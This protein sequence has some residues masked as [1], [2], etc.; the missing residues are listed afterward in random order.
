MGLLGALIALPSPMA[1]TAFGHAFQDNP[2]PLTADQIS[3]VEQGRYLESLDAY[4]LRLFR[5]SGPSIS[6]DAIPTA[7]LSTLLELA[8]VGVRSDLSVEQIQD[9][10]GQ[11]VRRTASG[12]AG[13]AW[14]REF[15]VA[16]SNGVFVQQEG[17]AGRGAGA[18]RLVSCDVIY[19][20]DNRQ[21]SI[22]H[23]QS[24]V[25]LWSTSRLLTPFPVAKEG[26]EMFERASWSERDSPGGLIISGGPPGA[27]AHLEFRFGPDGEIDSA[28]SAIGGD[29]RCVNRVAISR[30]SADLSRIESIRGA[31]VSLAGAD[32]DAVAYFIQVV[33]GSSQGERLALK[34]PLDAVVFDLRSTP[35][36]YRPSRTE[37][38]P[39]EI[40]DYVLPRDIP[41]FRGDRSDLVQLSEGSEP[42]SFL[43]S[44]AIFVATLI[45][46]AVAWVAVKEGFHQRGPRA[47]V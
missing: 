42:W 29:F 26:I 33:D 7:S 40:V 25:A 11:L 38:W 16:Q 45:L 35:K 8:K 28:S 34:V 21:V 15:H 27:G 32:L 18:A 10:I 24:G 44:A 39:P 19:E 30:S 2:I 5:Y 43:K 17:V 14:S 31:Y 46:V 12:G 36:H 41:E 47:K 22:L 37:T 23:Y 3:L 9:A 20:P 4:D 1:A 6:S 13:H